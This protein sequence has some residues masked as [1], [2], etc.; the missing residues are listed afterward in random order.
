MQLIEMFFSLV[1]AS[2]PVN[3]SDLSPVKHKKVKKMS[4]YEYSGIIDYWNSV[5][6]YRQEIFQIM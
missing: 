4:Q 1:Q 2:W 5:F 3:L 6:K